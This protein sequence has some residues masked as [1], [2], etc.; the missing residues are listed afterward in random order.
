MAA[1]RFRCEIPGFEI[2]AELSRLMR[3]LS[4]EYLRNR[5][6]SCPIRSLVGPERRLHSAARATARPSA[7][8][9]QGEEA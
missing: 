1:G 2:K 8:L 4:P 6:P 5:G 9:G 3:H 7:G